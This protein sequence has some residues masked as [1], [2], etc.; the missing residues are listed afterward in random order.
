MLCS[1]FNYGITY[2]SLLAFD[3]IDFVK[4]EKFQHLI[5]LMFVGTDYNHHWNCSCISFHQA[6]VLQRQRKGSVSSDASASTDSNTYYEDDFSSTEEDSSQGICIALYFNNYIKSK[7]EIDRSTYI[8]DPAFKKK[9]IMYVAV[10]WTSYV[11]RKQYT[12][13][14]QHTYETHC[15]L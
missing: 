5:K 10:V 14:T 8:A 4:W 13:S 9:R 15:G 2:N 11:E 7:L 1:S 12:C 3:K 6:C